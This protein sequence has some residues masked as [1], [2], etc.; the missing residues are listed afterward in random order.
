MSIFNYGIYFGYALCMAIE[1]VTD[2]QNW[3]WA[4]IITGIFGIVLAVIFLSPEIKCSKNELET[5][6]TEQ[7]APVDR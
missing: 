1:L 7:N 4:Y 6:K 3:I 5:S 2:D